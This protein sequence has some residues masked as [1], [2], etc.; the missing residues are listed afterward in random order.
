MSH[1]TVSRAEAR[2]LQ[3]L[4]LVYLLVLAGLVWLSIASYQ[5]A[6]SDE[7]TVSVHA[8]EAG[9]QLNVGGDVRMNGAIVGRV[10]R[11]ELRS[12]GADIDL[13]I[14]RADAERIPTD[15]VARILPTTLFGQKFVELRS[16]SSPAGGHLVDGSVVAEDHSAEAVELTTVLDDLQ[17]VLTAVRPDRLAATLG[18]LATGLDGRGRQL[19]SLFADSSEYLTALNRDAPLLV[20]DLRLLERVA[21]GYADAAPDFLALL[22]HATTTAMTLQDRAGQLGEFL[23]GVGTAADAGTRL[24]A[25]VRADLITQARLSRPTLAL[26]AEYSPEFGCVIGGFLKNQ[27][28]STAQVRGNRFQGYFTLG[29]QASGYT[30][31]DRLKLG[32][33]GTGPHCRGL[34]VAPVP[35]PSF[36]LDD[37]VR[38]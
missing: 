37:G 3:L 18:A 9:Q 29:K 33:L 31:A 36:Q 16:A 7:I 19:R 23:T 4:G 21:G 1:A 2:R 26:L 24:L 15:A 38:R 12:G 34:P 30:A 5:H 14:G 17:P 27:E 35:Y 6:F 28:L 22:D 32:D 11:V 8:R 13:R 20:R 10:S 25:A